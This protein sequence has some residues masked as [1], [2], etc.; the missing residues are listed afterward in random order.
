MVTKKNLGR[1]GDF[2]KALAQRGLFFAA[3]LA[4]VLRC[5]RQSSFSSSSFYSSPSFSSSS[6]LKMTT[7]LF[8]HITGRINHDGSTSKLIL[9]PASN[10]APGGSK[11]RWYVYYKHYPQGGE[12]NRGL[13]F[14]RERGLDVAFDLLEMAQLLVDG[15]QLL[16]NGGEGKGDDKGGVSGGV[17]WGRWRRRGR[18]QSCQERTG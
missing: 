14:E 15:L 2:S 5:L 18:R 8:T 17:A 3:R 13:G 12:V 7:T 11:A 9:G 4:C 16:D 1:W 10:T 6:S